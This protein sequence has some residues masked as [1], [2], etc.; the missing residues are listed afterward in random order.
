M[1]EN[2]E[3]QHQPNNQEEVLIKNDGLDTSMKHSKSIYNEDK[4]N[5]DKSVHVK[6]QNEQIQQPSFEL[7][8]VKQAVQ[9]SIIQTQKNCYQHGMSI[10]E[11]LYK[12]FDR[13]NDGLINSQDFIDTIAALDSEIILKLRVKQH[14]GFRY[15]KLC[16]DTPE[17]FKH[18]SKA[19]DYH[20]LVT[21]PTQRAQTSELKRTKLQVY[22]EDPN[23]QN[24]STIQ[25]LKQNMKNSSSFEEDTL[26]KLIC[27]SLAQLFYESSRNNEQLRSQQHQFIVRVQKQD[28]FRQ[29]LVSLEKMLKIV[30]SH[31]IYLDGMVKKDT[32]EYQ[33]LKDMRD[34]HQNVMIKIQDIVRQ[35]DYA[36]NQVISSNGKEVYGINMSQLINKGNKQL[37][38]KPNYDDSHRGK[39]FSALERNQKLQEDPEEKQNLN[40][41]FQNKKI[42]SIIINNKET[43]QS[44]IDELDD[45]SDTKH[46]IEIYDSQIISKLILPFAKRGFNGQIVVNITKIMSHI[47]TQL[48][49]IKKGDQISYPQVV[50]ESKINKPTELIDTG[51]EPMINYIQT[52]RD[53]LATQSLSQNI[54][55]IISNSPNS[56]LNRPYTAPKDLYE[57][58]NKDYTYQQQMKDQQ[59]QK[60]QSRNRELSYGKA[61]I[62]SLNTER[63]QALSSDIFSNLQQNSGLEASKKDQITNSQL[64]LRNSSGLAIRTDK[65]MKPQILYTSLKPNELQLMLYKKRSATRD[66]KSSYRNISKMFPQSFQ[67]NEEQKQ[68]E[69]NTIQ[70]VNGIEHLKSK[71]RL[72]IQANQYF[73]NTKSPKR[74]MIKNSTQLS[75]AQHNKNL[76][77]L[78]DNFQKL[79]KGQLDKSREK[80]FSQIMKPQYIS[81]QD[82]NNQ[83]LNDQKSPSNITDFSQT[84]SHNNLHPIQQIETKIIPNFNQQFMGQNFSHSQRLYKQLNSQRQIGASQNNHSKLHQKFQRVLAFEE[85]LAKYIKNI[86]GKRLA[87]QWVNQ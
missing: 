14:N 13:D 82:Q 29:G 19:K 50:E 26:L 79:I 20:H 5:Q 59:K 25:T 17:H 52:P 8:E 81:A 43:N 40:S 41:S 53:Q 74:I 71:W 2:D 36:V 4:I 87:R 35:M 75:E 49:L 24:K 44:F 70:K 42:M 65:Q 37:K 56:I 7:I 85:G 62:G 22:Q 3:F 11:L 38:S 80:S 83:T 15:E 77:I 78:T 55:E 46:S 60:S 68:R 31:D 51:T 32:Q 21:S 30:E 63:G 84:T 47:E 27:G 39:A 54:F 33:V 72:R 48:A 64:Y 6:D 76:T 16:K 10:F 57:F 12:A 86:K 34:V 9:Q 73:D 69:Q 45:K 1:K 18:K 61:R 66:G 58:L 28:L 67:Q 23:I